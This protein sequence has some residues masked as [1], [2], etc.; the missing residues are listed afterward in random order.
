MKTT[1]IRI[2]F[3]ALIAMITLSGMTSCMSIGGGQGEVPAVL[4]IFSTDPGISKDM[5][6]TSYSV[7]FGYF[8]SGKDLQAY[9]SKL[10]GLEA[11]KDYYV[12]V[13]QGIFKGQVQ[14]YR[15]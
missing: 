12:V 11:N 14:A 1:K 7:W 10:K 3:F 4:S 5:L 2:V 8:A 9:Q 6:I 15:R 13:I